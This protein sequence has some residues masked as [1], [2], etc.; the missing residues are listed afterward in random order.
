MP[1]CKCAVCHLC[2]LRVSCDPVT[3]AICIKESA[4]V[5][6]TAAKRLM[7]GVDDLG[8]C[9]ALYLGLFACNSIHLAVM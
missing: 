3:T 4:N 5:G 9:G 8:K 6:D 2:T 1:S 7:K